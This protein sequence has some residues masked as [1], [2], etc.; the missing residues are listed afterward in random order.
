MSIP[1]CDFC[2]HESS[3]ALADENAAYWP[4]FVTANDGSLVNRIAID[5]VSDRVGTLGDFAR[6]VTSVGSAPIMNVVAY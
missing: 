4:M 2:R 3:N 5:R 6:E 1:N